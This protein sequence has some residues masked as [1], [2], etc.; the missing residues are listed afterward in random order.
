MWFRKKLEHLIIQ[1]G[2]SKKIILGNISMQHLLGNSMFR[3]QNNDG[4]T[5]ASAILQAVASADPTAF[6]RNFLIHVVKN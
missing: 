4:A 6:K 2:G 5:V 3:E 1:N